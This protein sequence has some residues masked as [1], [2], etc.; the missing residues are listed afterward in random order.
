M[1]LLSQ[2]KEKLKF[3]HMQV[4]IYC[5]ND[6]EETAAAYMILLDMVVFLFTVF[7]LLHPTLTEILLFGLTQIIALFAYKISGIKYRLSVL[8]AQI[9]Q[10]SRA[11]QEIENSLS[12]IK[13]YEVS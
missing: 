1:N 10:I 6:S 11:R 4:C 8:E 3:L 2:I 13:I 9:E 5:A 12:P 7:G